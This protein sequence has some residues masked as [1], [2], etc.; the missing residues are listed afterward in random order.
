MKTL[1][2]SLTV[3]RFAFVGLL[4]L[5]AF[6][7]PVAV[8]AS[9]TAHVDRDTINEGET[10]TLNLSVSGGDEGQPDVSPL[11]K[12]FEV[13]GTGQQSEVQ[14]IN[15]SVESHRSW[16]IT[17]SPRQSGKLVIPPITVGKDASNALTITVLPATA[18]SDSGAD[19]GDVFIEVNA[20]PDSVY[21]QAQ[22]LYTVRLYYAAPLRQGSLSEP[23]LEN[24]IVQ[25]LGDD[26]KYETQRGGRRYQVI[27]RRYAIFPQRSGALEIPAVVFDGEVS[28]RSRGSGDP[29]FD[30]FNPSTRH[31][32]LR[33]RKLD[34]QVAAQ[35]PTYRGANWLPAQ[36]I[37]L[38]EKWSPEA[39]Q[40]RV[41]EPVTRTVI[42]RAKGLSA[43]Q[44]PDLPQAEQAGLKLYPDQPQTHTST[45]ADA[46]VSER[47]LK[48]AMIPTQAGDL[49]LP[50]IHLDWWD[51]ETKRERSAE[52]PAHTIHVL[53]ALSSS[54][55][56]SAIPSPAPGRPST[57]PQVTSNRP[58]VSPEP[59][60]AH[61]VVSDT[62]HS[63]LALNI[64]SGLAAFFALAWLITVL[65]WRR[66][67]RSRRVA[68]SSAVPDD[69]TIQA[70][71]K[72]VRQAC[73]QNDKQALK[74]ALL[75]WARLR[76]SN[77]PPLSLGA[78]ARRVAD[79]RLSA[80]I[81]RLDQ[82]LYESNTSDWQT[83]QLL[84]TFTAYLKHSVDRTRQEKSAVL[85]PL[86]LSKSRGTGA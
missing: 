81:A 38:E 62:R 67:N 71:V 16:A 68:P 85:E 79:D 45:R 26:S 18:S 59:A 6:L 23:T 2:A 56:A 86:H 74:S 14:I 10:F 22:L 27:E 78:L 37:S 7:L 4:L 77:E 82:F 21:V 64:W 76:W 41:G 55:S 8:Q 13:L 84:K 65:L 63:R 1:I 12:A 49:I 35:P 42:V 58:A 17:L 39:P 53:P 66:I 34:V 61:A 80:Q 73:L 52:L 20:K 32:R 3:Q 19:Q 75:A 57:A 25:K 11:Q 9:V 72:C 24:A 54:S 31:V 50:A 5:M 83:D 51:T 60:S 28:D 48:T 70:A 33:S 44:L 29:F 69:F 40:F 15:G 47:E 36:D 46:L 43:S 30:N